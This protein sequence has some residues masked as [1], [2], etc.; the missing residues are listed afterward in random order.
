M[1]RE[2]LFDMWAP[3]DGAW[4]LWAK[5]VL[6]AEL[7][8]EL[9]A[10]PDS[11]VAAGEEPYRLAADPAQS[12]PELDV[13]WV[14]P[15]GEGA[16]LVIDLP[17]EKAVRLALAVAHRGYRPVPLFNACAT[18]H[19]FLDQRTM[20]RALVEGAP[21]LKRLGLPPDAPP[22]FL[23]DCRRMDAR[24]PT[25]PGTYDN[26][27][28]VFPQ[29]FPSFRA[30]SSR[31]I[32][33]V[34]LALYKNRNVQED[35]AHVLLRWEEGGIELRLKRDGSPPAPLEVPRPGKFG[36]TWHRA[37]VLGGLSPSPTQGFGDVVPAPSRG[38]GG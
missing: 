28:C 18:S 31:G 2:D 30:L 37:I 23:L 16:A 35:L 34:L 19:A 20:M 38:G 4:S 7:P 32:R 25:V 36:S 11:P 17:G 6:F 3:A 5:P 21:I 12:A 13:A 15:A 27:W 14:P 29:D 24:A 8:G 22:A 26:R 1:R 10:I 9:L 33:Q